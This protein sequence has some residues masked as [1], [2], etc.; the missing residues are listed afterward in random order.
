MGLN[1]RWRTLGR[2]TREAIDG[3]GN[4]R[5]KESDSGGGPW[6]ERSVAIIWPTLVIEAGYSESAA[7]LHND[8]ERWFVMSNHTE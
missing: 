6:P 1:T 2:A 7:G 5:R 3:S 4:R 8:I